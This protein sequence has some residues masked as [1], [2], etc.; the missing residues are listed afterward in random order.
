MRTFEDPYASLALP[1][2][3][4]IAVVAAVDQGM[5]SNVKWLLPFLIV[6]E[7]VR[8]WTTLCIALTEVRALPMPPELEE[9]LLQVIES[10]ITFDR[11][12]WL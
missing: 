11:H 5:Y 6:L 3:K 10:L 2:L 4:L 9:Y 12:L 7:L 8:R 1:P